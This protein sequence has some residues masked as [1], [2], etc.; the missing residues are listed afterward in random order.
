MNADDVA[1]FLRDN[2]AF[3]QQHPALLAELSLPDPH[4]GNAVSLVERQAAVLRERVKALE[5]RLAELIQ[6]GRGNDALS[7]GVVAW[8]RSLLA[9]PERPRA[10]QAAIDELQRIFDIPL[11]AI[12]T[13]SQPPA[14]ADAGAARLVAAM[15]GPVCG[16]DIE[17]SAMGALTQAWTEVRSAALIPLR[18]PNA[19]EAFGIIA[20]GSPDAARFGASMGTAVLAG[21]GELAGA[22]LAPPPAGA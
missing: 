22:A 12:R 19:P 16:S 5:L 7:R 4:Q 17:L 10:P 3:F 14:P 6:I 20:L 15:R 2:P 8:T 18:A 13:W 1:R 21:I 11:A 9:A